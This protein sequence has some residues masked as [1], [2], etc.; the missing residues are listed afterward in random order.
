MGHRAI[1][2]APTAHWHNNG[3]EPNTTFTQAVTAPHTFDTT[4]RSSSHVAGCLRQRGSRRRS[5][6]CRPAVA[7]RWRG[8]AQPAVFAGARAVYVAYSMLGAPRPSATP[9]APRPRPR[10]RH[11][12]PSQCSVVHPPLTIENA[13]RVTEGRCGRQARRT[14]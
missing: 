2:T 14:G 11:A 6:V 8:N 3:T 13:E 5:P 1:S 7:A 12:Y 10:S 4:R 9:F